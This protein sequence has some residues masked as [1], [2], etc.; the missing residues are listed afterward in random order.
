MLKK[1]HK[2][3][4]RLPALVMV[5]LM[6][7]RI[8]LGKRNLLRKIHA[9]LL[10]TTTLS[11]A[12]QPMNPLGCCAVSRADSP[13]VNAD[14]TVILLW[15]K[16]RQTQ[17]FIR[18]ADFKTNASDIG[19]LVPSP[20]RPQLS[21][22]G[23]AAFTLLDRITMPPP[24]GGGGFPL[25]CAAQ[26]P[27][28]SLSWGVTVV[29]EKRVAGFDATVLTA[30]TG[31]D[32]VQ[33]LK[34]NGYAYSPAVAEWA[35]PYLGG[36]WHFTALKVVKSQASAQNTVKAAA[37]RISF[38][39]DQPLFPYREPESA[40]SSQQLGAK[41]RLLRIYFIAETQYEGR[42][43]GNKGWSGKAL[44]S[45]DIT[46]HRTELLSAL[47]LPTST[48]PSRW[49]LTKIDDQ[50]PYETA[51]GDVYF[52]PAAKEKSFNLSAL[53]TGKTIELSGLAMMALFSWTMLRKRHNCQS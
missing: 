7:R 22:S 51:A 9:I 26:A 34:K 14:Q 47:Q 46:A 17:H 41:N 39:T 20:S 28:R 12:F 37:L 5:R 48:G 36:S 30:Q 42:I 1:Q 18:K 4:D 25:G 10:A 27:A 21:E 44:W 2:S 43:N 6:K 24:Q 29:E 52:S 35:K 16:D 53:S 50:W 13:V 23:N 38:R 11:Q 32:L 19:F 31:E 49:W 15:D 45:G 33:W 3:I 40:V 8:D